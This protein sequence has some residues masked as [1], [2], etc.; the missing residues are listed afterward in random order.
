MDPE[1]RRQ[2]GSGTNR[3]VQ[4]TPAANQ[5]GQANITIDVRDANG[6]THSERFLATR[7]GQIPDTRGRPHADLR[8]REPPGRAVRRYPTRT[9]ESEAHDPWIESLHDKQSDDGDVAKGHAP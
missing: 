4:V 1:I 7:R 5:T 3:T 8:P 2:I 9:L 6:A